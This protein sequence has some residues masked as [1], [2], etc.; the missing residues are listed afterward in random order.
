M[1][2]VKAPVEPSPGLKVTDGADQ[3]VDKSLR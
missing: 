3:T 1:D 2:L